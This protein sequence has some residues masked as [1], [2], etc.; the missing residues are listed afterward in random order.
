[1][2]NRLVKGNPAS[3]GAFSS[4]ATG[5]S[6]KVVLV[7]TGLAGPCGIR[8]VRSKGDDDGGPSVIT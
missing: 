2:N 8:E 4:G 3:H 6:A 7:W 5:W 1:M